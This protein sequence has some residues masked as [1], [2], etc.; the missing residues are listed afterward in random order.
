MARKQKEKVPKVFISYS[1]DSPAHKKW[2]GELAS[3]LVKNGI[4][5]I[6]DQWDLGL[7]DDVPKF[8]EKSVAAAD[9]VLMICTETYVRKTDEGKG[10][11]GYEAMIVTGELVRDLGT[12]KFIPV[13]RQKDIDIV[14]PK[15]VST[16]FYINLS[17]N[18]N[19][20]EQMELLLRELH[21]EPASRKPPLGKSPFA[22]QP[23]GMETPAASF[24]PKS[25]PDLEKIADD[26][27]VVYDTALE[28]AR[29]GDLVAWRRIVRQ[30]TLPISEQLLAWRQEHETKVPRDIKLLQEMAL[31]GA[32][33]Y[34]KLFSIALAG[35]ESGREKFTNQIGLI[36]EILNPRGWNPAGIT[37]IVNFPD[38]VAYI[39]QALYGA[40]CLQTGQ[41]TLVTKFARSRITKSFET[42]SLPLY[43]RHQI[44][45]WPD[46]LGRKSIEAW[47]FL[48]NLPDKWHWLNKP[49][50]TLE[51]F[52]ESLC[53]YYLIL[54][55]IEFTDTI[56]ENKEDIL[57][58]KEIRLEVPLCFLQ[59]NFETLKRAYRLALVEPDQVKAIWQT[60]GILDSKMKE[61]WPRWIY[62]LNEW[63]NRV[64]D[65]GFRT[66]VIHEKIFDDLG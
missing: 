56:S 51:E 31:R 6:L 20:D 55:V 3:K 53:A 19:F 26:I 29:E 58:Q 13:I 5:V 60:K 45:G 38:T 36:D 54:N 52:R 49:F 12:S 18:Q 22:Q 24:K 23:S 10:G 27:Q 17:D 35:V 48:V 65:F 66:T 15:S 44:V 7:G 8:M 28:V 47:S 61:L 46:T 32:N 37:T 14:L 16:R 33:I 43:Q 64:Y 21:Q 59:E 57:Q 34:A 30:A 50:S 25:I 4:D 11:V 40:M 41:I 1:H 63:L 39:Y 42:G 9:R 62:H 2:V